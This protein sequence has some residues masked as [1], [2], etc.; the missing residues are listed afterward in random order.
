[1]LNFIREEIY[2]FAFI[3][4]KRDVA[5]SFL[6]NTLDLETFKLRE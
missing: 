5:H 4:R 2:I 3:I 6:Q 1:M